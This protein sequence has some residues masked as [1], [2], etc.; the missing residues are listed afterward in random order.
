MVTACFCSNAGLE[1]IQDYMRGLNIEVCTANLQSPVPAYGS[2]RH[3]SMSVIL[4][5]QE[6]RHI[7]LL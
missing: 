5:E 2:W 1:A 7:D 3:T 4:Q 6:C